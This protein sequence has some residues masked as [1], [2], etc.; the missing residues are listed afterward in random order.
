VA[1]FYNLIGIAL[2]GIIAAVC[3]RWTFS[4]FLFGLL[5]L[6]MIILGY[7]IYVLIMRKVD[8]KKFFEKAEGQA[9]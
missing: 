3:V 6:G 2:S 9:V 8:T 5:P 1:L 4:L 7:F